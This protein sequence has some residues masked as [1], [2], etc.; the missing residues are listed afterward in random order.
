MF[1]TLFF[2]DTLTV[3]S[4]WNDFVSFVPFNDL[5][6]TTLT[7]GDPTTVTGQIPQAELFRRDIGN[8]F[9]R[10]RVNNPVEMALSVKTAA[11]D[12][13]FAET[14]QDF[15]FGVVCEEE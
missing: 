12:E 1:D 3:A 6:I 13:D 4:L 8:M 11:G 5:E 15:V 2:W 10:N 14:I 9:R 7:N